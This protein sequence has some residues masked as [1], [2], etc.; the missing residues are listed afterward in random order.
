MDIARR[1]STALYGATDKGTGLETADVN[2]QETLDRLR[3]DAK[4]QARAQIANDLKKFLRK[5][6]HKHS[7]PPRR[8][9]TYEAWIA[10]LHPENATV[11]DGIVT[12]VDPRFFSEGSDHRAIWN[13]QNPE[14]RVDAIVSLDDKYARLDRAATLVQ[15]IYRGAHL[16]RKLRESIFAR[17]R[18]AQ[19]ACLQ[20]WQVA[21]A[22]LQHRGEAW[23]RLFSDALPR[24]R[25]PS[26]VVKAAEAEAEAWRHV[27]A[28]P[29]RKAR[30]RAESKRMYKFL[31]GLSKKDVGTIAAAFGFG[32][33]SRRRKRKVVAALFDSARTAPPSAA[34][35]RRALKPEKAPGPQRRSTV[36]GAGSVGGS[37]G[38]DALAPPPPGQKSGSD[39]PGL[40]RFLSTRK[41][42]E[43]RGKKLWESADSL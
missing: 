43:C 33:K 19:D 36:I 37:K 10:Q 17:R 26:G 32:P 9:N 15:R 6:N 2:D 40:M 24:G 27:E 23:D 13:S 25:R 39:A 4:K 31:Q 22:P 16:R 30:F 18:A 35:L 3:D 8:R 38:P 29:E 1:L 20:A 5:K 11:I 41:L 12:D 28:T 21:C 34:L 7:P 14:K 42:G